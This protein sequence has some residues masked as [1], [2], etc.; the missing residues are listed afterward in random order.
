MQNSSLFELRGEFF[1]FFVHLFSWTLSHH[2][3]SIGCSYGPVTQDSALSA[4]SA[5]DQIC[6]LYWCSLTG[7]HHAHCPEGL[8]GP[9]HR[10]TQNGCTDH[11]QHVL[12]NWPEGVLMTSNNITF[13][14]CCSKCAGSL[15]KICIIFLL[16]LICQTCIKQKNYCF[17]FYCIVVTTPIKLQKLFC[18]WCRI[19]LHTCLV[20]FRDSKLPYW[21]LYQRLSILNWFM[22]TPNTFS[23]SCVYCYFII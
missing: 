9:V 20:W 8:P 6:A 3:H 11:R 5:W 23:L 4:H 2:S 16:L 7:S 15:M 13:T 19:C 12:P 14:M 22:W 1:F 21:I 17:L 18:V 10:H